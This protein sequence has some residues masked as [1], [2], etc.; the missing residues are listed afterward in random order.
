[1]AATIAV[2]TSTLTSLANAYRQLSTDTSTVSNH[3]NEYC[4]L[5]GATGFLLAPLQ[6]FYNAARDMAFS[7][8]STFSQSLSGLD[9]QVNGALNDAVHRENNLAGKC[10]PGA[11]GNVNAGGGGGGGGGYSG[12]SSGGAHS[13]AGGGVSG[14]AAAPAA[15]IP[16]APPAATAPPAPTAPPV[17]HQPATTG[18]HTIE[19]LE[20]GHEDV[21]TLGD[22]GTATVQVVQGATAAATSHGAGMTAAHPG[23]A[24][25]TSGTPGTPAGTT[26]GGDV[27]VTFGQGAT[28]DMSVSNNGAG[29]IDV[30]GVTNDGE[31]PGLSH[32]AL[33]TDAVSSG[34]PASSSAFASM[35]NSDP[36]G[37][38]AG[39]LQAAWQS[40]ETFTFDDSA[41]TSLGANGTTI[42]VSALIDL[43]HK[44]EA[45]GAANGSALSAPVGAGGTL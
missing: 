45:G 36:L 13:G 20:N 42:D 23:G 39:D 22:N 29:G 34:Q 32:A 2:D 3:L 4:T 31:I 26:T 9:K 10:Q 25:G 40:R 7:T 16:Q 41:L 11:T 28:P 30:I 12:G 18:R 17:P 43:V 37:R 14:G 24:P 21:I 33:A 8:V 35:A 27:T 38:S 5:N 15:Q 6:P 44:A 1:M 19:V